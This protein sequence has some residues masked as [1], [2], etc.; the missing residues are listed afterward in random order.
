MEAMHVWRAKIDAVCCMPCSIYLCHVLYIY[1]IFYIFM[2]W[3]INLC[4]VLYFYAVFYILFM[5]ISIHVTSLLIYAAPRLPFFVVLSSLIYVVPTQIYVACSMV[6][7][8]ILSKERISRQSWLKACG[9]VFIPT[10]TC[11][12]DHSAMTDNLLSDYFDRLLNFIIFNYN[13]VQGRAVHPRTPDHSGVER[14]TPELFWDWELCLGVVSSNVMR[15]Q[16]CIN[17]FIAHNYS[18]N[19]M[20]FLL[21]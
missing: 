21:K 16:L 11:I 18:T 19:H 8:N 14:P 17:R 10:C 3:F 15:G 6:I 13:I 2:T 5:S 9:A 1:A 4:C 7:Y 12:H 20:S